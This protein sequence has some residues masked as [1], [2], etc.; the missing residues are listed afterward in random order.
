MTSVVGPQDAGCQTAACVSRQPQ[1]AHWTC[2]LDVVD[3]GDTYLNLLIFYACSIGKSG[4]SWWITFSLQPANHIPVTGTRLE[5]HGM[6]CREADVVPGRGVV[7][8]ASL[9]S[10][11]GLGWG[12]S[13]G[14]GVAVSAVGAARCARAAG[15][16]LKASRAIPFTAA[17]R[18]FGITGKPVCNQLSSS[19]VSNPMIPRAFLV[20][21]SQGRSSELT[22]LALGTTI[23][24]LRGCRA[25]GGR[26]HRLPQSCR[27]QHAEHLQTWLTSPGS[28]ACD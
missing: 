3:I 16:R 13:A 4:R 18:F 2:R 17:W 20:A 27:C 1:L 10:A 23:L 21:S 15:A 12:A 14:F 25:H 11:A 5:P 7:Q 8:G 19:A 6:R 26:C 28:D 24:R 9:S 22:L